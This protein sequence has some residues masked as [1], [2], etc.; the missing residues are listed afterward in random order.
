M[1]INKKAV[2]CS[3]RTDFSRLQAPSMPHRAPAP[4]PFLS[5]KDPY[6]STDLGTLS[7]GIRKK[8]NP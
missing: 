6:M 5:G 4:V 8:S 7:F 2:G 1:D 3:D